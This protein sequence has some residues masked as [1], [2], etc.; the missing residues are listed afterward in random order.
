MIIVGLTGGFGCGKSVVVAELNTHL[1]VT[2]VDCDELAKKIMAGDNFRPI[3]ISIIGPTA[4]THEGLL[5]TESIAKM[6]FKN[7]DVKQKL[8]DALH[9]LV[10]KD[11]EQR[12]KQA[13]KDGKLLFVI[14]S[15]IL[16]ETGADSRCDVTVCVTCNE[17]TQR[18]RLKN[19]RG[20]TDKEIDARLACQMPL[21]EKQ[22]RADIIFHNNLEFYMLHQMINRLCMRIMN[23][24]WRV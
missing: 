1:F 4:I 15:A 12:Q 9:P 16:F 10:W 23:K 14:E 17:E 5:D 24:G 7:S 8:E 6:I 18:S 2:A 21:K 20:F 11:V 19:G 3:L 22:E 13:E